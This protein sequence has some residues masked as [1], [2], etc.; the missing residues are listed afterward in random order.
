MTHDSFP[1]QK[2]INVLK[3]ALPNI[4][5]FYNLFKKYKKINAYLKNYLQK[6]L[7]TSLNVERV[8]FENINMIWI[9]VFKNTPNTSIQNIIYNFEPLGDSL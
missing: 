3:S 6:L 4:F 8:D 2:I 5:F 9:K 1:T 7:Y